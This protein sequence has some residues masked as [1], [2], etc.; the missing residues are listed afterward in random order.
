MLKHPVSLPG[1]PQGSPSTPSPSF[2][3]LSRMSGQNPEVMLLS[4]YSSSFSLLSFTY[5]LSRKCHVLPTPWHLI[6]RRFKLT[7]L[8]L[9]SNQTPKRA[10]NISLHEVTVAKHHPAKEKEVSYQILSFPVS[11]SWTS[12]SPEL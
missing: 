5:I 1:H 7:Q 11:L 4:T 2:P 12:Q 9:L 3:H 8:V 10:P 6:S